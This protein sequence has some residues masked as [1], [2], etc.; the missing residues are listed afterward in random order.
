MYGLVYSPLPPLIL[1][2]DVRWKTGRAPLVVFTGQD[3]TLPSERTN[4]AWNSPTILPKR[5]SVHSRV[6]A[7]VSLLLRCIQPVFNV[8][9]FELPV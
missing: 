3:G 7:V 6:L 8:D 9:A 1:A 4:N 2:S 5:E